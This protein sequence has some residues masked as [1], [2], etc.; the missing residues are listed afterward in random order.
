VNHFRTITRAPDDA[1]PNYA[2]LSFDYPDDA[3]KVGLGRLAVEFEAVVVC[4]GEIEGRFYPDRVVLIDVYGNTQTF[5]SGGS[6][7]APWLREAVFKAVDDN[8]TA[9]ETW[10]VE[11]AEVEQMEAA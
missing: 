7:D 4:R 6:T 8:W 11:Q 3:F 2:G 1:E 5:T 10:C 9:I